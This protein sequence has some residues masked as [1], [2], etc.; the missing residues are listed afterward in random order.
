MKAYFYNEDP[1]GSLNSHPVCISDTSS[2]RSAW[3]PWLWACRK[4]TLPL[5]TRR[6]LPPLPFGICSRPDC[7]RAVLQEQGWDHSIAREDGSGI[8]G[9]SK[10]VLQRAPPWGWRDP[11]HTRWK[12]LLRREERQRWMGQDQTGEGWPHHSPFRYSH[13][14]VTITCAVSALNGQFR[15][16]LPSVYHRQQERRHWEM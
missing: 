16:H 3:G 5:P 2:G 7:L 13:N 10:D 9:K 1:V 6:P 14:L 12:W 15:R 4:H 8:R 11:V